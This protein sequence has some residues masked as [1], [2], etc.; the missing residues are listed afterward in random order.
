MIFAVEKMMY[1]FAFWSRVYYYFLIL[2]VGMKSSGHIYIFVTWSLKT[3][4]YNVYIYTY[5]DWSLTVKSPGYSKNGPGKTCWHLLKHTQMRN[6][7]FWGKL[8]A[9]VKYDNITYDK[10]YIYTI[11]GNGDNLIGRDWLSVIRLNWN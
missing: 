9:T 7:T 2:V 3:D 4:S 1:F 10:L 11:K 6:Y 8:V 5:V